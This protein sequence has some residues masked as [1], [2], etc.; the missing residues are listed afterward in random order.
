VHSLSTPARYAP[1]R[2]YDKK[3]RHAANMKAGRVVQVSKCDEGIYDLQCTCSDVCTLQSIYLLDNLL[4]SMG[5]LGRFG[6][7]VD[8]K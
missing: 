6:W 8:G 4:S 1:G 7:G 5:A 3:S 2:V